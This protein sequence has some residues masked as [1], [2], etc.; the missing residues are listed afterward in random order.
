MR[1]YDERFG[2]LGDRPPYRDRWLGTAIFALTA[3]M[4]WLLWSSPR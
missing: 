2:E 3:L 1:W 4:V